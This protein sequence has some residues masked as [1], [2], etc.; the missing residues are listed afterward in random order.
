MIAPKKYKMIA[1]QFLSILNWLTCAG[2]A[3]AGAMLPVYSTN[4][5]QRHYFHAHTRVCLL[6][7]LI[8][9]TI[10]DRHLE[11]NPQQ[12]SVAASFPQSPP[13]KEL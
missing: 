3:A 6:D 13:Q 10:N 12:L 8:R 1:V 11:E 2:T 4:V 5:L 9:I 7:Y